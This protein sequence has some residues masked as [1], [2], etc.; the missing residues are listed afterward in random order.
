MQKVA[1]AG[2]LEETEFLKRIY[3]LDALPSYDPRYQTAEG[4][5]N[6]HRWNN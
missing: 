4:D 2:G 6:Q 1:W 5:I 3:D